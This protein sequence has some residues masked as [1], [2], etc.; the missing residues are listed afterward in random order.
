MRRVVGRMR[1]PLA[2]IRARVSSVRYT[3]FVVFADGNLSYVL[4]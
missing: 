3:A 4:P 2:G 1:P